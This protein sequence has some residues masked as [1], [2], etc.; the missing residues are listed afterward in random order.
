MKHTVIA[1]LSLPAGTRLGLSKDQ[2]RRRAH[3]L[4]PAGRG[5]Y[6]TTAPVQFKVGE[7][8]DYD[9]ELPKH[10]ATLVVAVQTPAPS[11]PPPAPPPPPAA[12][13]AAGSEPLAPPA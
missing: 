10:L 2:A 3:A 11:P 7:Q 6:L 1:V 9:G 12:P 4:K 5:Y 13:A 8:V